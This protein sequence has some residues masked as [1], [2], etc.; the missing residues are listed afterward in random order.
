MLTWMQGDARPER[1][2]NHIL[3]AYN[4][5]EVAMFMPETLDMN[6]LLEAVRKLLQRAI[7]TDIGWDEAIVLADAINGGNDV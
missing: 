1:E 2:W 7:E 6:V 5:A 4:V 3:R